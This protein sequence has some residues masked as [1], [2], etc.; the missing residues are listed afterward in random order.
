M[1]AEGFLSRRERHPIALTV[2]VALNLGGA[3]ALMLARGAVPVPGIEAIPTILIRPAPPPAPP[4]TEPPPLPRQ[5]A[6]RPAPRP[7]TTDLVTPPPAGAQSGAGETLPDTVQ[8]GDGTGGDPPSRPVPEP[9]FS[10]ATVDPR[11]AA[12]LQPP[13]PPQLERL[14]VEGRVVIEVRIGTDGRVTAARILFADD[15]DFARVTEQQAL[16]RWRFR[17][18]L[19]DGVPVDSVKRLTVRFQLRRS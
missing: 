19:R 15:D 18:A 8:P 6:T 5:V 16:A 2:A 3:T 11:Y 17:P 1:P 4:R 7:T 13:Y 14:S 9:V 10:E 12:Q